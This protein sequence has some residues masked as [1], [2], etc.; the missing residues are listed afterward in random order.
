VAGLIEGFLSPDPDIGWPL[1]LLAAGC[2]G[3]ILWAA[4]AGKLVRPRAAR[5]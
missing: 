1:R 5:N 2:S 3:F 4:L